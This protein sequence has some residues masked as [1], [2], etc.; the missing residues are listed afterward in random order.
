MVNRSKQ[1]HPEEGNDS[2]DSAEVADCAAASSRQTVHES[3]SAG[4]VSK[5]GGEYK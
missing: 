3:S 2:G 4:K 5:G 1:E